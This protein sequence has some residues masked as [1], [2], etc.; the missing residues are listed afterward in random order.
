MKKKHLFLGFSLLSLGF[1]SLTSCSGNDTPSETPNTEPV[2]TETDIPSTEVSPTIDPDKP[3]TE[4]CIVTF[5]LNGEKYHTE[6]FV[7]NDYLVFPTITPAEGEVLSDWQDATGKI[8]TAKRIRVTDNAEYYI[9]SYEVTETTK[10][11]VTYVTDVAS[12]TTLTRNIKEGLYAPE[13]KPERQYYELEG[14]YTDRECTKAY[15][16][17]TPVTSE[18]T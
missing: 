2:I 1:L 4:L 10:F 15:D 12:N 13:L 18:I 16:F 6:S 11:L 8:I 3:E 14:W 17:T 5:Y 9:F 7:K